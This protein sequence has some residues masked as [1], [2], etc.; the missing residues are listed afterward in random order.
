[1]TPDTKRPARARTPLTGLLWTILMQPYRQH[2]DGAA[3]LPA[4]LTLATLGTLDV[5]MAE[6]ARRSGVSSWLFT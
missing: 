3:W 5:E 2:K 4:N 6:L 1:M